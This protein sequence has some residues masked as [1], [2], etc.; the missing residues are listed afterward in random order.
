MPIRWCTPAGS[1]PVNSC[2]PAPIGATST[3]RQSAGSPVALTVIASPAPAAIRRPAS[4]SVG[5]NARAAQGV[6]DGADGPGRAPAG[7]QTGLDQIG[8]GGLARRPGDPD[9]R[10]LLG[11]VP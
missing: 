1:A 6:A 2:P 10:D 5:T 9:D 11:R 7:P 4:A 8:R 3:A